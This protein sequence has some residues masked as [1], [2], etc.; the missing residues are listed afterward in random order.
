MHADDW[1]RYRRDL[2]RLGS[3][4]LTSVAEDCPDLRHTGHVTLRGLAPNYFKRR[5]L[6]NQLIL[7]TGRHSYMVQDP[8]NR[9]RWKA[10]IGSRVFYGGIDQLADQTWPFI[11][12]YL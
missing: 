10:V 8:N 6:L 1:N 4:L 5:A 12:Q 11:E 7:K 2:R 9:K 3:Q